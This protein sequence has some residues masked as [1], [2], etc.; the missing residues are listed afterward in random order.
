V[1]RTAQK[2]DDYL[3]FCSE[4]LEPRQMLA[5]NVNVIQRHGD[6]V[7]T[8]DNANNVIGVYADL[9]GNYFVLGAE[10]TKVNGVTNGRLNVELTDDLKI[11]LKHGDNK[12]VFGQQSLGG[13]LRFDVPDDLSIRTGNGNDFIGFNGLRAGDDVTIN[14]GGGYDQ[15]LGFN[16]GASYSF[17]VGDDLKVTTRGSALIFVGWRVTDDL[18]ISTGNGNDS[19]ILSGSTVGGNASISTRGGDDNVTIYSTDFFGNVT[20]QTHAGNDDVIVREGDIHGKLK[21]ATHAGD[22]SFQFLGPNA[23]AYGDVSLSMGSGFDYVAITAGLSSE[24][25]LRITGVEVG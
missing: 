15:V 5:G 6:V 14:T 4:T 2:R 19:I 3:E 8:G 11:N 9:A 20:I 24:T 22:D 18:K 7:I 25:T 16:Y 13:Q 1:R 12:L 23:M 10:G 21:V 17:E